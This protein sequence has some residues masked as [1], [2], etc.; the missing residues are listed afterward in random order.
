VLGWAGSEWT[1]SD[2]YVC[3][4]TALQHPPGDGRTYT[5]GWMD[6]WTFGDVT[7]EPT[8]RAAAT[9]LRVRG[10]QQKPSGGK[11]SAS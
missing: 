7:G 3:T 8:A 4:P 2:D 6:G 9:C 5:D 1:G 11:V 10:A